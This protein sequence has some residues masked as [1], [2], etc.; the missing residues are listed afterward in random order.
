MYDVQ[1]TREKDANKKV[2][3]NI[4]INKVKVGVTRRK[5][6]CGFDRWLGFVRRTDGFSM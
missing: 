2:R 5:D 1:K 6:L 4:K 3:K